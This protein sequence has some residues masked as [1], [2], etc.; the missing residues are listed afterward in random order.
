VP[1]K[2]ISL[3]E[4][5]VYFD[6]NGPLAAELRKAALKGLMS[7]ALRAKRDI[8]AKVIPA[9]G[10][11][12]PV[13][14]GIY[15]AGWQVERLPEG[16][17]VY[18]TVPTAAF[19]EYGVPAGNVVISNK[20]QIA[21]AEWVQRKLGGNKKAGAKVRTAKGAEWFRQK[22]KGRTAI[23]KEERKE[24]AQTVN[25]AKAKFDKSKGSWLKRSKKAMSAGKPPPAPPKPPAILTD[26]GR[27]KNDYG[28][29]W[30]IA[31]AI[32]HSMKKRGIFNRGRGLRILE[33]YSK[34]VLPGIIKEEC[35]REMKKA[36]E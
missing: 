8:V 19:V 4:A 32:L 3:K 7:A 5:Q 36:V 16:A 20:A 11:Q 2:T 29:A 18:N 9:L 1:I 10:G 25:G 15:R 30:H 26:K 34:Q 35:E 13:D 6:K 22:L 28:Y 27:K 23:A 17:T 33:T 14:R 24:S 12:K 21:L 31:G